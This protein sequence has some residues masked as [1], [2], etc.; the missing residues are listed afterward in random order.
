MTIEREDR[1]NRVALR[2]DRVIEVTGLD[3]DGAIAPVE[4]AAMVDWDQQ[5]LKGVGRR[6]D[7]IVALLDITAVFDSRLMATIRA[8][9]AAGETQPC[10]T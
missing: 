9:G 4:E 3:R 5:V 7:A 2:V 6:N 10:P 8:R 1:T